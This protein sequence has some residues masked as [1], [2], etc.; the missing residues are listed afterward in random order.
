MSILFCKNF[1]LFNKLFFFIMY[2]ICNIVYLKFKNWFFVKEELYVYH[3]A[4]L[5]LN[6]ISPE[7]IGSFLIIITGAM[8]SMFQHTE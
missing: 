4:P 3:F 2:F 6:K 5:P 1:F 8:T 7:S